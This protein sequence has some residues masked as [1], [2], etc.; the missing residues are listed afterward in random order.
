MWSSTVAELEVTLDGMS[1]I[2]YFQSHY[3][4]HIQEIFGAVGQIFLYQR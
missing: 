4:E 1:I 2:F 3:T